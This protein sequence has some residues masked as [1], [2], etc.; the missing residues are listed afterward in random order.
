MTMTEPGKSDFKVVIKGSVDESDHKMLDIVPES[1][2]KKAPAS[3]DEKIEDLFNQLIPSFKSGPQKPS[4]V[5]IIND[6]AI[7]EEPKIPK[8]RV[9]DIEALKLL[10]GNLVVNN[11]ILECSLS[12]I[13]VAFIDVMKGKPNTTPQD[14]EDLN[15]LLKHMRNHDKIAA[16][17]QYDIMATRLMERGGDP[18]MSAILYLVSLLYCGDLMAF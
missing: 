3:I 12:V 2:I 14:I 9:G 4:P 13:M 6:L 7:I 18:D 17:Q 1:A 10:S 5:R 11:S 8:D 16:L 15:E